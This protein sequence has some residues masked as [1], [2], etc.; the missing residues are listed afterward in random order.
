MDGSAINSARDR[1]GSATFT[2]LLRY[3]T[4][5]DINVI[6]D[7]LHSVYEV[8]SVMGL[9]IIELLPR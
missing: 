2:R 4:L 3:M 7:Q 6:T 5:I 8:L 1:T 9:Y